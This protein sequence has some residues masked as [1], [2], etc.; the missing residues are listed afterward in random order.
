MQY[1]TSAAFALAVYSDYLC[2]FGQ[3]QQLRCP[4]GVAE[5]PELVSLAKAQVRSGQVPKNRGNRVM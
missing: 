2:G 5:A 4:G 1:V 3:Q